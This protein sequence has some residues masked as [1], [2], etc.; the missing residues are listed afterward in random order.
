ML[1]ITVGSGHIN[2]FLVMEHTGG[3]TMYYSRGL[4]AAGLQWKNQFH[5][6]IIT[7]RN[8]MERAFGNLKSS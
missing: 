8:R 3:I 5:T 6:L 2:S 1:K 4:N 7:H